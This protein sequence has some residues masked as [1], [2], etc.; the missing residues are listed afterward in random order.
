LLDVIPVSLAH[1]RINF[2]AIVLRLTVPL[3]ATDFNLETAG[4]AKRGGQL[5]QEVGDQKSEVKG[6][7]QRKAI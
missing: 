6:Q 7:W 4:K 5:T 2:D 3:I 1:A